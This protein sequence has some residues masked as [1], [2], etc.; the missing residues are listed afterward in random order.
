[1]PNLSRLGRLVLRLQVLLVVRDDLPVFDLQILRHRVEELLREEGGANRLLERLEGEALVV[2]RLLGRLAVAVIA[3]LDE[4]LDFLVH[5][6]LGDLEPELRRLLLELLPLDE[7]R[8]VLGLDVL[9]LGSPDLRE[10]LLL[11]LVGLLRALDQLVEL[12]T[13]DLGA[14]DDR[15]RFLRDVAAAAAARRRE[16]DEA[17]RDERG[18]RCVSAR[19][20]SYSR[21]G[22]RQKL[23]TVRKLSGDRFGPTRKRP[24]LRRPDG[25]RL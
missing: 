12:G 5:V 8:D 14:V 6:L 3:G 7:E 1:M 18:V 24:R 4:L 10:L 20:V 15:D 22:I 16:D 11:R 23:R 2:Q 13:G 17:E 25:L 21:G 19:A 9:V